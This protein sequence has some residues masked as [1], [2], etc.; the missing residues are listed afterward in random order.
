M[1]IYLPS[2]PDR[3]ALCAQVRAL[4]PLPEAELRE[5]MRHGPMV[6]AVRGIARF[7]AQADRILRKVSA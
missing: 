6:R 3:T 2:T 7:Q 5:K 4:K 1:R